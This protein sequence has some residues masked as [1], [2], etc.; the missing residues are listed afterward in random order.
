AGEIVSEM[1]AEAA[2][3]LKLGQT[4]LNGDAQSKL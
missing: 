4:Y 2:D 1:V 3:M